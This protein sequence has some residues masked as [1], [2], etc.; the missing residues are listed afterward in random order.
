M[1]EIHCDECNEIAPSYDIIHC[2]TNR[3]LATQ[4]L[5]EMSNVRPGAVM[6]GWFVA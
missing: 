6:G 4:F 5:P 2:I 1:K 3:K